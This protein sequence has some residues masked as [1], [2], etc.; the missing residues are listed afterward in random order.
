MGG[1]G[2]DM[3]NDGIFA[4]FLNNGSAMGHGSFGHIGGGHF[5]RPQIVFLANTIA[6]ER[7]LITLILVDYSKQLKYL[8]RYF[9]L[10]A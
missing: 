5:T 7:F 8:Y 10:L 4:H 3:P 6:I 2:R 1:N 9:A